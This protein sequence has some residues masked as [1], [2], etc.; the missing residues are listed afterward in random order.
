MSKT[1]E[2]VLADFYARTGAQELSAG[3]KNT[4]RPLYEAIENITLDANGQRRNAKIDN[5][6]EKNKISPE[7]NNLLSA[8]GL[9]LQKNANEVLHTTQ[10]GYGAELVPDQ[11]LSMN[12]ID[13]TPQFGSFLNMLPGY[14]GSNMG[15]KETV[16]VIGDE[17]AV[18]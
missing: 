2:E 8:Q 11:I 15:K 14:H 9:K 1:R 12:V 7:L 13:M 5:D 10:T 18:D 16:P 17:G 3:E 6:C 4:L